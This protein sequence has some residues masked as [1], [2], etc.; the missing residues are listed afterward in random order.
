MN[1]L[2]ARD[3]GPVK[4][5]VD[6]DAVDTSPLFADYPLAARLATPWPSPMNRG[7]GGRADVIVGRRRLV[8][9]AFEPVRQLRETLADAPPKAAR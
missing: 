2:C 9:Y 8:A 1:E 3:V 6:S 7:M 4:A 5:A